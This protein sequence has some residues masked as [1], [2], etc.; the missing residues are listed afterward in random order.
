[1]ASEATRPQLIPQQQW[2]SALSKGEVVQELLLTTFLMFT[3]VPP[4][5]IRLNLDFGGH[6]ID[7][8]RPSMTAALPTVDSD[9][10]KHLF[11]SLSVSNIVF[12]MSA[13][14]QE[15][16]VLLHSTNMERLCGVCEALVSLLFPLVWAHA[17]VPVLPLQMLQFLQAPC[18]YVMGL[19]TDFLETQEGM[20]ALVT[21]V[22]VHLDVDKVVTP[23]EIELPGGLQVD[24]VPELPSVLRTR[25]LAE[26]AAAIPPR[27][28]LVTAA[29]AVEAQHL[30]LGAPLRDA[31]VTPEDLLHVS[32]AV[33]M[34][35]DTGAVS[36][37]SSNL[38][39]QRK[40]PPPPLLYLDRFLPQPDQ[41]RLRVDTNAAVEEMLVEEGSHG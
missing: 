27:D 6:H 30:V 22:I 32:P 29:V 20:D 15:Q 11:R 8:F 24:V 21:S 4:P 26:V 41:A 40:Q 36:S 31:T 39:L 18:P 5:G 2:L 9:C 16:R 1:M 37:Y 14:L 35:Q 38:R 13:L 17:L 3:R 7:F 34:P 19:H 12:I 25:L 28:A 23:M 10:F 33:L